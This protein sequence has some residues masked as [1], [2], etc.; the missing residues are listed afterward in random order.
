MSSSRPQLHGVRTTRTTTRIDSSRT[1]TIAC[2]RFPKEKRM[3]VSRL[4]RIPVSGENGPTNFA[5]ASRSTG[6]SVGRD[7][8]AQLCL[9]PPSSHPMLMVVHET[10]ALSR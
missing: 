9:S 6:G 7:G 2:R 10:L 4:S 3:I 8:A 1:L 5:L